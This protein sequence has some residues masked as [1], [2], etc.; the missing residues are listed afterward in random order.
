MV[1]SHRWR[2]SPLTDGGI[3]IRPLAAQ[4]E[5]R[6]GTDI[7]SLAVS[8]A[9]PNGFSNQDILV[10]SHKVVSKAEGSTRLLSE[11]TPSG[12]AERIA[13]AQ[14]RDPRQVEVI[15]NQS[16]RVLRE[17][18]GVLICVTHHGFVC[19]NAGVD[20][21]NSPAEDTVILLPADPDSSAR[22][23][24]AGIAAQTGRPAP[25]V[26]IT[27]SFGRAWRI[28]QV[29]VAIGCAGL[30]PLDDWR[31]RADRDGRTLAATEIGIADAVAAAADLARSKDSGQPLVL[32]SGLARFIT[33]ED[34][35]GAAA[36][37][38]PAD[39]DM[40]LR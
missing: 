25:A 36:L 19:A 2:R 6:V 5:V 34:G 40:F 29:D 10:I 9:G 33:P 15:L 16:A 8:A 30:H 27:D 39:Q 32:V 1:S 28:G 4:A 14:A 24:R 22:S 35:P 21:S 20:E 17:E 18:H 11:V 7:A 38:R 3:H 23:I 12:E 37:R 26:V 13:A 31:D